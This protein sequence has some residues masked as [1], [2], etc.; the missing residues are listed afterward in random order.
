MNHD[1][2]K[3][4]LKLLSTQQ[5]VSVRQLVEEL[6][7]SP[8]TVRRDINSLADRKLLTPIRGGARAL[9]RKPPPQLAGDMFGKSL[10]SSTARKRGIARHA[11][12]LC[13]DGDTIIINGG[14]TT[15]MMTEYLADRQ[16]TI[17]TN[18]FLMA[19]H[20][21]ANSAN[22]IV[23]PGGEVYREQNIILGAYDS[24]VT[25]YH[26]ASKIFTSAYGL[27]LLG[28]TESDPIVIDAEKRLMGQAD[29]LIVL[30]DSSKFGRNAGLILCELDK[31]STV[32]TDTDVSDRAV[33]ML[34]DQG[35][36]VVTVQPR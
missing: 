27:S 4:L 3:T 2:H 20:L 30:A 18:S 35:I 21:I 9:L 34:E 32:I 25:R 28:L 22:D 33:R 23:I 13:K 15:F 31:I 6:D 26:Y 29:E 1:R 12:S 11:A 10:F 17:L 36:K 19:R 5:W 14:S 8:A 16:L 7:V 24:D